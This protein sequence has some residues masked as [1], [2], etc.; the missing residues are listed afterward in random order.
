M[1]ERK[2]RGKKDLCKKC[3]LEYWL[4]LQPSR[5]LRGEKKKIIHFTHLVQVV[6]LISAPT[7]HPPPVR[8]PTKQLSVQPQNDPTRQTTFSTTQM[9]LC[10]PNPSL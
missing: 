9:P 4:N 8:C 5:S 2:F 1:K 3:P 6:L 7:R 10:A